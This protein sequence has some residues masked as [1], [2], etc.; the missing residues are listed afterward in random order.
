MSAATRIPTA[1]STTA[2]TTATGG[3]SST[4]TANKPDSDHDA[5]GFRIA[6]ADGDP[7]EPSSDG[8]S[9][10]IQLAEDD[11][12]GAATLDF[13]FYLL[14]VGL[15][16]A[17]FLAALDQTIVSVALSAIVNEFDNLSQVSWVGTAYL[18]TATAFIP[19]YGQLADVFGR[20]SV[21]LGAIFV[22]ELGSALCGAAKSMD[23]LIA[24]RAIAGLGG[25]GII[26]LVMII[27]SDLV[28]IEKRGSYNGAVAACFG[29]AAIA[30][31]LVGGAFVDHVLLILFQSLH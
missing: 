19:S 24:A 12:P 20:K 4:A 5:A 28:P 23:M 8:K 3:T 21:F 9:D 17:V 30:G 13:R 16:M 10:N 26:S 22:F 18:L 6:G 1:S 25:G 31:P 15:T 14:V 11:K 27:I 7:Q 29:I 2:S